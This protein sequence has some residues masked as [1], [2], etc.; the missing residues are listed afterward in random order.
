[1]PAAERALCDSGDRRQVAAS[2]KVGRLVSRARREMSPAQRALGDSGDWR[3]HAT[4]A[5]IELF[6]ACARLGMAAANALGDRDGAIAHG[7]A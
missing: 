6:V 5:G 4:A 3:E 7:L 1:M 2:A